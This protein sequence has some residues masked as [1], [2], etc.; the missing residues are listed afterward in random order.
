MVES[1]QVE[2]TPWRRSALEHGEL[3]LTWRAL[4]SIITWLSITMHRF[5]G[6]DIFEP[7]G[8]P[9]ALS[10]K[11]TMIEKCFAA[12][13]RL[14]SF[15]EVSIA[16]VKA[17]RLLAGERDFIIHH[18]EVTPFADLPQVRLMVDRIP[19]PLPPTPPDVR[20]P[21]GMSI[22]ELTGHVVGAAE[23]SCSIMLRVCEI[24]VPNQGDQSDSEGI[25]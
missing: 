17:W 2:L 6:G 9:R 23:V 24:I 8:A 5:G 18:I 20:G 7:K 4:E 21:A 13:E 10:R 14:A 11:L 19:W 22:P 25:S 12:D 15:S 1:P 16:A 3:I